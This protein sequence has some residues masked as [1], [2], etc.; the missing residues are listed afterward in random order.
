MTRRPWVDLPDWL[1]IAAIVAMVIVAIW[2]PLRF[3]ARE[4]GGCR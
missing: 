2:D 4:V 1:W 3:L